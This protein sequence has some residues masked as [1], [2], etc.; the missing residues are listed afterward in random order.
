MKVLTEHINN[1]VDDVNTI[2]KKSQNVLKQLINK[3]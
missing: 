3:I 2:N 1:F